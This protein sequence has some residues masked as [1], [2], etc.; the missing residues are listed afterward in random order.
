MADAKEGLTSTHALAETFATLTSGRLDLQ[1]A[2]G[3]ALRMI[4][5]NVVQRLQIRELSLADYL[6]AMQT[7]QGVGARGGAI[8]DLLHLQAARRGKA[9]RILT[10]NSRDFQTFA[11]DLKTIISLPGAD[12]S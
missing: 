5:T 12:K 7:S 10:I 8:F 9:A 4:Q 2:G 6:Q 11:P 1:L 3:D